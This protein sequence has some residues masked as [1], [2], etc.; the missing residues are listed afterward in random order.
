MYISNYL[1]YLSI[2]LPSYLS[3]WYIQGAGLQGILTNVSVE[4]EDLELGEDI[5]NMKETGERNEISSVR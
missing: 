5:I 1:S 2:Y 4:S 3:I